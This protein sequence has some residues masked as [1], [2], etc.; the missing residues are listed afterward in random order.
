MD[1]HQVRFTESHRIIFPGSVQHIQ[2]SV[3]HLHQPLHFY[4]M[5]KWSH[6]WHRVVRSGIREPQGVGKA[7]LNTGCG[8]RGVYLCSLLSLPSPSP[9]AERYW[10][11]FVLKLCLFLMI[12]IQ[13]WHLLTQATIYGFLFIPRVPCQSWVWLMNWQVLFSNLSLFDPIS[14]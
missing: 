4:A 5:G 2:L 3:I 11:L 7:S 14:Q 1:E 8:S 10:K 12:K 9:R 6:L 13:T